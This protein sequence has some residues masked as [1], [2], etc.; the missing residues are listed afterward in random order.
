M[1]KIEKLEILDKQQN[2]YYLSNP[3]Q[4]DILFDIVSNNIRT[5]TI[6]LRSRQHFRT[7][8][9]IYVQTQMLD[10]IEA[11]LKTRIYWIF[12]NI[13]EYPKCANPNCTNKLGEVQNISDGYN[14]GYCCQHCAESDLIRRSRKQE[15]FEKEHGKGI[16]CPQKLPDV[17]QKIS[18]SLSNMSKELREHTNELL[19]QS[20]ANKSKE[21]IQQISNQRKQTSLDKYGVE[22]PSQ[23]IDAREHMSHIM[24][25]ENVQRKI[26]ASKKK[27]GTINT[28]KPEDQSYELLCS[29]FSKD[30]V[31]RQYRSDV[32]PFNCDFYIKSIDTYIE[33]NYNWTHGKHSFDPN[34]KEDQ[35]IVDKWKSKGTKFYLIAID[36]W[37]VRDVKKREYAEKNKLK[38]LVFWKL[39]ELEK[40]ISLLKV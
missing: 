1:K 37:T 18:K 25:S 14:G 4:F 39:E 24:A 5:Y 22:V 6:K 20:W 3:K 13:H 16:T 34:S 15:K 7:L 10:D 29:H 23:R 33:C 9:W 19:R 17:R 38:Y 31:I 32:Y 28:S 11:T 8:V 35:N 12:N 40:W 36:V 30:D 26:I 21:R 27:N 2:T